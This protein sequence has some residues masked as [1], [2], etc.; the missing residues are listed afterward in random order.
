MIRCAFL[1][2][3]LLLTGCSS[4]E[5]VWGPVL[6]VSP[7]DSIMGRFDITVSPGRL[8]QHPSMSDR[9]IQIDITALTNE[10]YC[11]QGWFKH[12]LRDYFD[13]EGDAL[14]D[15][16]SVWRARFS[17]DQDDP[18]FATLSA[19]DPLWGLWEAEGATHLVVLAEQPG[20]A[21]EGSSDA[22]RRLVLPLDRS[23]WLD[24]DIALRLM[25][26]GLVLR[27]RRLPPWPGQPEQ[28]F[29]HY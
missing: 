20:G 19:D 1:A 18:C 10:Q 11:T 16:A 5:G 15:D 7:P 8:L 24:E 17:A 13:D 29:R 9:D 26:T 4:P 25:S 6:E 3:L 23:R 12:D 21:H 2:L 27:T 14:R 22:A 28:K